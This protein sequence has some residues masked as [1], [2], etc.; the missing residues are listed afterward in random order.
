MYEQKP[1]LRNL[2]LLSENQVNFTKDVVVSI[3]IENNRMGSKY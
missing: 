3:D 2:E 1:P